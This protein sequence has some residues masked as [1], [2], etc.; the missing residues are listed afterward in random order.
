MFAFILKIL[1]PSLLK[2]GLGFLIPDY[3]AKA[4]RLSDQMAMRDRADEIAQERKKKRDE[5]DEDL[6]ASPD[7]VKRRLRGWINRH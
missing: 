2:M 7:A 6:Y 3:K 4:N 5:I 1:G